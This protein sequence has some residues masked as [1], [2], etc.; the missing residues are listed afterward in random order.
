MI[1]MANQVKMITAKIS[2]IACLSDN[3]YCF[4][5]KGTSLN[6]FI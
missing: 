3:G 5:Q 1:L 4:Y 6:T 2:L